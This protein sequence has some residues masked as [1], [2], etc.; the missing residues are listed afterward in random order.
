MKYIWEFE[1]KYK[2][3]NM[4]CWQYMFHSKNKNDVMNVR[5]I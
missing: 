2:N 3:Y 4:E 1:D 5:A